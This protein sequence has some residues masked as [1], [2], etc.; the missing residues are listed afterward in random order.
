MAKIVVRETKARITITKN[1]PYR[2]ATAPTRE[3][4][5]GRSSNKPYCDGSHAAGT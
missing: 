4:R 2:S 5:C 1:G 3:S